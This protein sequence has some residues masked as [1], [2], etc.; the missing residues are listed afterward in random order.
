MKCGRPES[1]LVRSFKHPQWVEKTL[2]QKKET[3]PI[4]KYWTDSR[5]ASK[6]IVGASLSMAEGG[7]R[8]H[9]SQSQLISSSGM[10]A[11]P[12]WRCKH[13]WWDAKVTTMSSCWWGPLQHHLFLCSFPLKPLTFKLNGP[14]LLNGKK[15]TPKRPYRSKSPPE[16]CQGD[17]VDKGDLRKKWD[18]GTLGCF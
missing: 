2:V 11:M 9:L 14:L 16:E 7:R 6:N 15:K 17:M 4:I 13:L 12:E 3:N 8:V 10:S 18:V 1:L 5:P